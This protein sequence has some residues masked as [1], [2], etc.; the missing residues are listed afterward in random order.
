MT[1]SALAIRRTSEGS[2]QQPP[3]RTVAPSPEEMGQMFIIE[4]ESGTSTGTL[5][6]H[7][8]YYA[9]DFSH[10]PVRTAQE[11]SAL[12]NLRPASVTAGVMAGGMASPGRT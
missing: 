2:F 5:R 6:Q 12:A 7:N 3:P 11:L 10:T 1:I 4:E 8:G 9:G